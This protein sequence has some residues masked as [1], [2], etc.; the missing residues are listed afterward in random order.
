MLFSLAVS[1]F[2]AGLIA[3]P[4]FVAQLLTGDRYVLQVSVIIGPFLCVV[5]S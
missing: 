4:I 5:L 2:L 3:Q 1:D